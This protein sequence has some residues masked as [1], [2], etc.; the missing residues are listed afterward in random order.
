[1]ATITDM[2]N[3]LDAFNITAA[4]GEAM[5]NN[6]EAILDINREQLYEEGVGKDGEPLPPY[7]SEAYARKKFKQRGKSI[8]DIF[9]TGRLQREMELVVQGDEYSIFS[10]V[11][12]SQY[13]IG[14]RPTVYGLDKEGKREAWHVVKPDVVRALKEQLKVV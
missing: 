1:M 10:K 3:R 6:T 11:P 7:K 9:K 14:A 12:Y 5:Q 8:V 13:V 2:A 4:T